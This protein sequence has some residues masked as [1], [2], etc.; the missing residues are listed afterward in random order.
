LG[1]YEQALLS[2][3]AF[4][5]GRGTAQ[6]LKELGM[7]I[8]LGTWCNLAAISQF[9]GKSRAIPA[10]IAARGCKSRCRQYSASY[11]FIASEQGPKLAG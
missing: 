8:A 4:S 2:F 7:P 5:C 10:N 1:D 3:G 6:A 11:G 9:N